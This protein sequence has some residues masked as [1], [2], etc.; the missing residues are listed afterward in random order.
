MD[1]FD[2]T[3]EGHQNCSKTHFM[4]ILSVCAIE[5]RDEDN[6]GSGGRD[7]RVLCLGIITATLY[8]P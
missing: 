8:I 2:V 6:Q 5:G 1:N 4:N 7:N 3:Y